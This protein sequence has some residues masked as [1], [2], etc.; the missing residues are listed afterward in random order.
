MELM[1]KLQIVNVWFLGIEYD[2]YLYSY[3]L[4]LS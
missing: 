1:H 3:D 4:V 2:G